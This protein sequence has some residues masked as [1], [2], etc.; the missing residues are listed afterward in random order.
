MKK[1][2]TRNGQQIIPLRTA[3]S[4]YVAE[5]LED[6]HSLIVE[7]D[8]DV[9]LNPITGEVGFESDWDN[10]DKVVKANYDYDT[11]LWQVAQ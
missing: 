10:L 7:T 2:Y 3:T 4:M 6:N 5:K 1:Y 8:E 11:D 9:Y